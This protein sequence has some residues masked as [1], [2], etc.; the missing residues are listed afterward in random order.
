MI[1]GVAMG[2]GFYLPAHYQG[3]LRQMFEAIVRAGAGFLALA[4]FGLSAS[5]LVSSVLLSALGFYMWP[6]YFACQLRRQKRR[7][8]HRKNAVVLPLY[9]FVM[10]FVFFIGF[11]AVLRVPGLTGSAADL[12]LLRIS[13]MTFGP[14]MLGLIGA[15][16]LLTALVPGSMLLLTASTILAQNLYRP[17]IGASDRQVEYRGARAGAAGRLVGHLSHA[18]RRPSH[19]RPAAD[20]L[21]SG[22]AA[23]SGRCS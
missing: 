3:G 10:L 13:K 21:Q 17:L 16:G 7:R 2:L 11:A 4:S 14:W 12:S 20:G 6:H 19:R 8:L 9:Q 22:H 23:L 15:A 18:P 1:L 5:W